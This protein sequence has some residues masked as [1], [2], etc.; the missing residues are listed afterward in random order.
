MHKKSTLIDR[1]SGST[2]VDFL[3]IFHKHM[4]LFKLIVANHLYW[5]II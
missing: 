2:E 1:A 4:L 3:Y 5:E